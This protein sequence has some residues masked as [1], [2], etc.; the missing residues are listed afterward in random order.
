MIYWAWRS[1]FASHVWYFCRSA[2]TPPQPHRFW[3]GNEGD[4][5]G[6]DTNGILLHVDVCTLEMIREKLDASDLWKKSTYRRAPVG[7][8]TPVVV[9]TYRP[10]LEVAWWSHTARWRSVARNYIKRTRS[11]SVAPIG[12]VRTGRKKAKSVNQRGL[13]FREQF[14]APSYRREGIVCDQTH[15]RWGSVLYS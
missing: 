2:P 13:L 4:D 7:H 14:P 15:S 11:C 10:R 1:S 3:H 8:V 6:L 9:C 12:E 5:D